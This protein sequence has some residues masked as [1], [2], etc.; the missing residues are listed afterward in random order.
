MIQIKNLG[1]KYQRQIFS[2]LNLQ[3][4]DNELVILLGPSGCGKS[5]LL[6][7]LAGLESPTTGSISGLE[8]KKSSVVF[9]ESR[10]LP[11]LTCQE[12][13]LL[14]AKLQSQTFAE[15]DAL[16]SKLN[17]DSAKDLYPASLSG[18]MKMRTAIARSLLQN[19]EVLFLD[20]PFSALDEPTRL[21]LQEEFRKLYEQSPRSI[22]FVTHS[23]EEACFL[24]TKILILN[25]SNETPKLIDVP[26]P[27]LR[28]KTL[29]GEIEYFNLIKS[30]RAQL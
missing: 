9:Q 20:E 11:W 8:N 27:K 18:G 16:L 23:I 1:K 17:L 10:L 30:L 28:N 3:F 26:L 13:V 24:G 22:F 29:R 19:P 25:N 7:I 21:F 5:T 6:K 2:N 15:A 4:E 12:N 14:P